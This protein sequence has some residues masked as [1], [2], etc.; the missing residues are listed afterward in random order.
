MSGLDHARGLLKMAEKDF[1][2]LKG[3]VDPL[4]FADEVFGFHTQQAAEKSL[5]AWLA[6]RG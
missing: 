1:A 2:A 4:V 5:K 6:A 3:M